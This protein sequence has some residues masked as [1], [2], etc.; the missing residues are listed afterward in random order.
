MLQVGD[1]AHFLPLA[2]ANGF[3]PKGQGAGEV[4][5]HPVLD[6]AVLQHVENETRDLLYSFQILGV[7]LEVR[8]HGFLISQV[9]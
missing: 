9:F 2:L 6:I 1:G 8:P 7:G 4:V 5:Q 3:K